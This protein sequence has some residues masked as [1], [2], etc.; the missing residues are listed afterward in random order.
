[1]AQAMWD[2]VGLRLDTASGVAEMTATSL[3]YWHKLAKA[4]IKQQARGPGDA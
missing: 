1:M 4:M 3:R 2:V